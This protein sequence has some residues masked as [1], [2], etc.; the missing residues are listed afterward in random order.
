MRLRQPGAKENSDARW[1]PKV[2]GRVGVEEAMLRVLGWLVAVLVG[3]EK[4][5]PMMALYF[6]HEAMKLMNSVSQL[7]TPSPLI[8]LRGRPAR[9]RRR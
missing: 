4:Q 2:K 1:A 9:V 7:V 5:L 3:V 8:I 6:L